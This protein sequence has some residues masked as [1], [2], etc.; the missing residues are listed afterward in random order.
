MDIQKLMEQAQMM[1]QNL[2]KIEEELNAT[3]YEGVSGSD[4]GVKVKVN[5]ANEVQEVLISEELMNY[6]GEHADD[7]KYWKENFR[8]FAFYIRLG[9]NYNKD[10]DYIQPEFLQERAAACYAGY[11]NSNRLFQFKKKHRI[12]ETLLYLRMKICGY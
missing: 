5:G 9:L 7:R 12:L 4:E 8:D 10:D 1:Q 3:I 2:G 11:L 6:F